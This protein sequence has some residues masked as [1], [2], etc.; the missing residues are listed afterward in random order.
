MSP[1]LMAAEQIQDLFANAV[2]AQLRGGARKTHLQTKPYTR[3]LM[4]SACPMATNLKNFQKFDG[5]YNPKQHMK[6]FIETYNNVDTNDDLMV[7]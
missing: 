6:N 5:K 4:C 1:N 3:E 2:K 7:K